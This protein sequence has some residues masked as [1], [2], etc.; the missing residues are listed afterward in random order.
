MMRGRL[1]PSLNYRNKGVLDFS[2]PNLSQRNLISLQV[3]GA[4][5]VDAAF[6]NPRLMFTARAGKAFM[7]PSLI[8]SKYKAQEDTKRDS[9]R[10]FINL[11]DYA[12]VP[13]L[14][15]TKIPNDGEIIYLRLRGVL[16]GGDLTD[17]GPITAIPPYDFLSVTIPVFTCIATA[18]NL[19]TA[20][21]IPDTLDQGSLN[22][23][24]LNFSQTLN[25]KNLEADGGSSLYY[26][27][28]PG[29]NPSIL[30]PGEEI[31]LTGVTAPDLYVGGD[32]DEVLFTL[33]CGIV[34][35]G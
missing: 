35:K 29:M 28:S 34:N 19:N 15:E 5:N 23:S 9:T 16:Q 2:V 26:S 10:I 18:P 21:V 27:F 20:G 24:L 4:S 6:T 31:G 17:F 32:T 1:I 30:R 25:L 3:Y 8:A 22:L 11:D 13:A 33:R 7:S 12:T 14:G